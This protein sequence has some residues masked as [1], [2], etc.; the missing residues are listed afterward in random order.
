MA[1]I[2]VNVGV[3]CAADGHYEI[4]VY[5]DG[6]EAYREWKHKD[7]LL[8][9]G[10]YASVK[11]AANIIKETTAP[12]MAAWKNVVK[13]KSIEVEEE[14]PLNGMQATRKI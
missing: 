11:E 1:I 12:N 6:V 2:T 10:P 9:L 14:T 3:N 13:T 7:E 8:P 5:K 4:I